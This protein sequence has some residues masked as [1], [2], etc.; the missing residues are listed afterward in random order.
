MDV[1]GELSQKMEEFIQ[2]KRRVVKFAGDKDE[3]ITRMEDITRMAVS[4]SKFFVRTHKDWGLVAIASYSDKSQS[5][6]ELNNWGHDWHDLINNC[7]KIN[8]E[9]TGKF[10]HASINGG[11]F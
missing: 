8:D 6:Q 4:G 1:V 5:L 2:L 10:L 7:L 9:E 11:L 3:I